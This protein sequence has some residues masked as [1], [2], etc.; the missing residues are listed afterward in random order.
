[1]KIIE[2]SYEILS[3]PIKPLEMLEMAGRTCYKSEDKI[4]TTSAKK[5][6]TMLRDNG[7]HAMIEF[8]GYYCKIY[9]KSRSSK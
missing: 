2:Q 6:V 5:F 7:H 1:M 3:K 8:G 4:T 9:Y